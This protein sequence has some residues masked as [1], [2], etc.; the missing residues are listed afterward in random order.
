MASKRRIR[1]KACDGKKKHA[2]LG[3]AIGFNKRFKGGGMNAYHCR[4][5]GC[6]HVGHTPRSIRKAMRRKLLEKP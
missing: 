5:C 4:F 2:S 3:A 1:R 6:Y